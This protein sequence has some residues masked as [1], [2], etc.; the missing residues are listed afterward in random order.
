MMKETGRIMIKEEKKKKRE[1]DE[2]KLAA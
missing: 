2:V 1:I